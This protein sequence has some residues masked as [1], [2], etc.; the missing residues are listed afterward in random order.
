MF[1]RDTNQGQPPRADGENGDYSPPV[2]TFPTFPTFSGVDTQRES[3]P[4]PPPSSSLSIPT[5]SSI[6]SRERERGGIGRE[7]SASQGLWGVQSGESGDNPRPAGLPGPD[8]P[9]KQGSGGS[10]PPPEGRQSG[11]AAEWDPLHPHHTQM[12][13]ESAISPEV[14]AERGYAT[15]T[16][17]ARLKQLGFSETQT[18]TPTLLIPLFDVHGD[19]AGYQSRP[20]QPR[21]DARGKVIKY[22]TPRGSG[23]VLDV[24]PGCRAHLASPHVPLFITEGI[25]KADSAA[26]KG[27]CC[28]GLIGVWNW[29]GRNQQGGTTALAAWDSIHLKGRKV[30]IVFDSDVMTK[31]AVHTALVRLKRY[32]E[33]RGADVLVIY[34]PSD[35]GAKKMGMDD[36]FAAGYSVGGLLSHATT[37]VRKPDIDED[38]DGPYVIREEGIFLRPQSESVAQLVRLTNFTAKI[39]EEIILDDG[40]EQRRRFRLS[41]SIGSQTSEFDVSARELDDMRWVTEHIGRGAVLFPERN[42]DRHVRTAIMLT[43]GVNAPQRHVYEHT[44]WINTQNGPVYLHAGGGVGEDGEIADVEVGLHASLEAFSLPPCDDDQ[45]CTEAVE[46][47]LELLDL[48]RASIVYPLIAGVFR[49]VLAPCDF[50]IHLAGAS[51]TFKTAISA[52]IQQFFGPKMDA[53][54]LPGSWSST[55]NSLETLAF[56]AKDA[57]LV[58]DDFAPNGPRSGVDR[59]HEKADRL[60]RGQGNKSGRGRCRP[61]GSLLPTRHPRGLIVSTGEDSPRGASLGARF[62]SLEMAPGDVDVQRLTRCQ[63]VAHD[64]AYAHAMA[65]FIR[66][67]APRLASIREGLG[68]RVETL[69][70]KFRH[71]GQ[72]RRFPG[73]AA[74]LYVGLDTFLQFA[75]DAGHV[76]EGRADD[77]QLTMFEALNAAVSAQD[78]EQRASHPGRRFIELLSSALSSGGAHVSDAHGDAPPCTP[79]GWGWR[80]RHSVPLHSGH[81]VDAYT[82]SGTHVGWLRDD[83][84]YLDKEAALKAVQAIGHATGAPIGLTA[85][86]LSKR[87]KDEGLLASTDPDGTHIP[88]QRNLGGSKRRVLHLQA[89]DVL[90]PAEPDERASS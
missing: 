81:A 74:D 32:L 19:I 69:R 53:R 56:H 40:I 67:V 62:L 68:S 9:S 57:V 59:L 54:H 87:L 12:L 44:G 41:A 83:S 37:E 5:R 64:G 1:T 33:G 66:W 7:G 48:C 47:V 27:L 38:E 36:Y 16:V 42:C 10:S 21:I 2:P 80:R 22:E 34:L 73:L 65:A 4:A 79:E 49:V 82:P 46:S 61:D 63:R 39:T 24:P 13:D 72:H 31:A 76:T 55:A 58:V 88:V 78:R 18:R 25:K 51:G 29:R 20:D 43:S 23:M 30:Y 14:R 77:I 8:R 52:L 60:F 45:G 89:A 15:V 11:G 84:L 86:T 35:R 70:Q 17:K 71:D 26:S 28:V 75:M 85:N 90:P 6:S 3:T 50:S